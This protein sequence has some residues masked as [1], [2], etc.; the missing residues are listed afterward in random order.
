MPLPALPKVSE[1][2]KRL[3]LVFPEGTPHRVYVVREM[4]ARTI[5][6]MLYVG[7]VEG[8]GSWM[9]PKHV[10]RLSN[11]QARIQ[12]EQERQDFGKAAMRPGFKPKRDRWY[13]DN[14]RESIRDETLREGLVALGAATVRPGIPTTSGQPR[15]ALRADFAELFNPQLQG[16][17]LDQSITDWQQKHLSAEAQ[18]RLRIVRHGRTPAAGAIAVRLPSGETRNMQAG[19]SSEITKRVVEEFAPRFLVEPAVIWISE[20]GNKVI[21]RDD[22]LARDLGL[23]IH[24]DRALPDIILADVADPLLLVFVEVVA[25]DGPINE[26]RRQA[27]LQVARDTKIDEHHLLFLTAFLDRGD[28]AFRKAVPNLAWGS[29]VWFAAEPNSIIAL[30]GTRPQGISKLRDLLVR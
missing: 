29:F 18:A 27:L 12:T 10:Y 11:A 15:Y 9:A 17:M 5:F 20:S 3:N 14:S 13:A 8:S 4:A 2:Q 19:T 22:A 7:A 26:S 21:E 30:D 1:I 23:E 24:P 6:A 25:T 16:D 28:A